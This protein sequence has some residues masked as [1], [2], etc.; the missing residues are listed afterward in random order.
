MFVRIKPK[1]STVPSTNGF[2]PFTMIL[3]HAHSIELFADPKWG[4]S[5]M[6]TIY[7]GKLLIYALTRLGKLAI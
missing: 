6:L 5:I 3:V 2:I 7:M 1:L 4:D